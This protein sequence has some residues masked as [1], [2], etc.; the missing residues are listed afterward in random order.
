MKKKIFAFLT[1]LCLLLTLPVTA[2]A[3]QES[4]MVQWVHTEQG[5]LS[6]LLAGHSESGTYS[7]SLDGQALTLTGGSIVK[8]SLPVTVYC[9]VDTSGT[10]TTYQ[11]KLIRDALTQIS[12]S[13]SSGDNMVVATVGSELEESACLNTEQARSE[14]IEAIASS[15]KNSNLNA[16]IVKSLTR[17]ASATDLNPVRVLVLLSDGVSQ[18]SSGYTDQEVQ[19]AIAKTRLPIFAVSLIENYSDRKGSKLLGSYAR[20]SCGGLHLTTV[21]EN[22]T[23]RRDATGQEFGAAIWK[24]I[25]SSQY[26][27]ADVSGLSIDT[28]RSELKLTVTYT[29]ENGAYTDTVQLD[30][31]GLLTPADA[32]SEPVQESTEETTIP[33]EPVPEPPI[34]NGVWIAVA[35]GVLAVIAAAVIL[36]ARAKAKR[37]AAEEAERLK[38]EIEASRQEAL[39]QQ[40]AEWLKKEQEDQERWRQETTK[41]VEK[42]CTVEL[43]DIPYGAHPHRYQV[44]MGEIVTFGRTSKARFVLESTDAQLSGVHF[45]L[46]I[47]EGSIDV[48]D[49]KSTNGTFVNG[50]SI[51]GNGWN[52]IRSGEKVRAGS[53]EYRLI[54]KEERKG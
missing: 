11:T 21:T 12:Q 40:E 54:V 34:S 3:A 38:Q 49:E 50:I 17:L 51:A 47:R 16:G 15:H 25:T 4:K 48:R 44:P 36:T 6:M 43:I 35:I 22:S 13:M 26:L 9:L 46:L 5:E 52:K 29:T 28:G 39:R 42:T 23:I 1:A 24:A 8:E 30:A 19:D 31:E 20:S 33:T 27:S 32:T 41:S 14:A 45:S 2:L 37:K 7:A 18:Q 10:L 53:S